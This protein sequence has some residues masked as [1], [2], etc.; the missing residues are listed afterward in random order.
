MFTLRAAKLVGTNG[1]V[2][3]IE[4]S[5]DNTALLK[6]NI[7]VNG[8]TNISLIKKALTDYKGIGTLILSSGS[9]TH[10][11]ASVINARPKTNGAVNETEMK[12]EVEV[13]TLDNIIMVSGLDTI[14]LLKIDVEGAEEQVLRGAENSLM[15]TKNISMELHYDNEA[16][17]LIKFLEDKGFSVYIFGNILYAERALNLSQ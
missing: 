3:S 6:K 1:K 9:A 2:L 10:S 5:D 12:I 15:I 17:Y 4:P 8:Y 14:D 13:D 16:E 7:Y 11:L